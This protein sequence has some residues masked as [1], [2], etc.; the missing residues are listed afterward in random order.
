MLNHF[1]GCWRQEY[2]L[3][4]RE[5]HQY[6]REK[7]SASTVE[8]R[9]IVLLY[10][11]ALAGKSFWVDHWTRWTTGAVVKVPA[12]KGGLTVL[13]H[14]LQPLYP[15]NFKC[16]DQYGQ[17]EPERESAGHLMEDP[18]DVTTY[19]THTVTSCSRSPRSG[20]CLS[21][22]TINLNFVVKQTKKMKHYL[23]TSLAVID[24]YN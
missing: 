8:V 5:C 16:Q 21:E 13:R 7:E 9:D 15:L 17:Y 12:K 23:W 14:P 6:S 10:D 11:D 22:L 1:W 18:S 4:L 3:E 2:L 19:C 20:K 24:S